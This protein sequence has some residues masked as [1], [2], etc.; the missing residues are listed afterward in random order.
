MTAAQTQPTEPLP[1][2]AYTE[3]APRKRR[4]AWPWIVAVLVVAGLAVAAW[5]AGE[6]IARD[7]V[8]SAI[9][10]QVI[11]QLALPADQEVDVAV[12]GMVLP[13]LIAGS[14]DDVTIA[15]D[16][17]A[18]GALVGDVTVRAQDIAIRGDAA[19]GAASAT[20]VLDTEQLRSLLSTVE[21]FPAE[22]VGLAEPNVTMTTEL[23]LFGLALPIG[24]ALT[25]G[26]VD[27]DIVL[28][29]ASL[30][31][32]GNDVSAEALRAQ[33]GAVADTVLRDWTICIA[34]YLPAGV[35]LAGISVTGEQVV[36]DLDID[37]AIVRD[38]AL[39]QPGACA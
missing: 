15:S 7:I 37:G 32:A 11:T 18:L 3:Q 5:F 24:V 12:E 34:S 6:W 19:A 39:Q 28:T 30:Q 33:F 29:P 38:P 10:Q 20:V 8:T 1:E 23:R 4:R 35:R 17:V 14:L 31:L 22:S 25:P 21:G 2:W 16:D 13:Q 27:G 9:R 26:A 36:A